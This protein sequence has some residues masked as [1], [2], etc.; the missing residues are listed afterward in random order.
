MKRKASS[1]EPL[2]ALR[3]VDDVLSAAPPKASAKLAAWQKAADAAATA[4]E[5]ERTRRMNLELLAKHGANAWRGT[6]AQRQA[7]CLFFYL[8]HTFSIIGFGCFS[9]HNAQSDV[10]LQSRKRRLAELSDA[11]TALNSQRKEKHL[12]AG[13]DIAKLKKEFFAITR[14]SNRIQ[15]EINKLN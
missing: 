9:V 8:A 4:L 7:C 10:V 15:S 11:S 14:K 6:G 5:H 1:N 13:N 2:Q 3:D 12:K